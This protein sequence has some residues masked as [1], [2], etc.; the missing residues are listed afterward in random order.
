MSEKL[1]DLKPVIDSIVAMDENATV[2]TLRE[3]LWETR[4]CGNFGDYIKTETRSALDS[5]LAKMMEE[6]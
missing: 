3:A 5:I 1:K 6:E 4:P 2:D